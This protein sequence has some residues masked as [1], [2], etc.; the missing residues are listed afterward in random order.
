MLKQLSI[1]SVSLLMLVSV[2]FSSQAMYIDRA[3]IDLLPDESPRQDVKVINDTDDNL[4]VR[5][6]VFDV[7]DPGTDDERRTLVK[8]PDDIQLLVTPAKMVVPP[9]ASKLLRIINLDADLKEEKIYRIN[10][11]PILPPLAE[12]EEET[13]VRL[14][15]A[16]Q[17]LVLVAPKNPQYVLEAERKGKTLSMV[18]SGNSYVVLTEGKQCPLPNSEEKDCFKIPSKRLYPGNHYN[19][20]LPYDVS[21]EIS[22]QG[23]ARNEKKIIP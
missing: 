2:S 15:V 4:Y 17:V 9:K 23:V 5:I 8:N 16:Y 10:V 11:T 18:N 22:L 7:T 20:D 3:I 19:V 21:A 12:T 14:V 6:D 13:K 1:Y